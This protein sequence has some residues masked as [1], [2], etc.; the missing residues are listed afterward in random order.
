MPQTVADVMTSSPTCLPLSATLAEAARCMRD[1]SI[2][3]VLVVDEGDQLRGLVTDRDIVVRGMASGLDSSSPIA[4]V[5]SPDPVT[6]SP[7]APVEEAIKLMSQQAIRR[8][9]VVDGG[10]AVGIVAIGDLAQERDPKSVL[11][12]ISSAAPSI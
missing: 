1:D 2:G 4:E 12:D 6:V 10:R 11:A 8:I 5:C 7:D 3:D 9:P